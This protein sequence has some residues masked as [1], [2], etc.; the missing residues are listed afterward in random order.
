MAPFSIAIYITLAAT[1]IA[2]ALL[3][4]ATQTHDGNNTIRKL[5]AGLAF[6]EAAASAAA[7]CHTD[8]T[9]DAYGIVAA[10]ARTT[11][12]ALAATVIYKAA[13]KHSRETAEET[14]EKENTGKALTEKD[15]AEREAIGKS[16][17]EKDSAEE[18]AIGKTP[19][20][21]MQ[22]KA[23]GSFDERILDINTIILEWATRADRPWLREGITINQ[24]ADDMKLH[25]RLLSRYINNVMKINFNQWIN[26]MK[27]AEAKRIISESP[28]TSMADVAIKAGFT[29]ATSMSKIFK[30]ITGMPPSVY[31]NT[32]AVS[33]G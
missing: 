33:R 17:T 28:D 20:E 19:S 5:L 12:T 16:L 31:R 9:T 32:Q 4:C 25:P 26:N 22:A 27:V 18:E 1:N 10:A 7:V 15:T 11:L 2:A 24:V 30:Q 8:G 21:E 29:D 6:A 3:L 13:K 14:A 23:Q